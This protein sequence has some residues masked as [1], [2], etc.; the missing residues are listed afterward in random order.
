MALVV[1]AQNALVNAQKSFK[2]Q[3]PILVLQIYSMLSN[4]ELTAENLKKAAIDEDIERKKMIEEYK[5]D[6]KPEKVIE[7]Y[8]I[9]RLTRIK[10]LLLMKQ[11]LLN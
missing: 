9:K 5:K 10:I 8:K 7:C 3:G 4:S 2:I 6:K 1:N 11:K